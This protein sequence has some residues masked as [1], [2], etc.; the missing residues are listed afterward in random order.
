MPTHL[1]CPKDLFE[2]VD[3]VFDVNLDGFALVHVLIIG[4]VG[5]MQVPSA[6]SNTPH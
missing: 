2:V 5:Q 1:H 3:I 4:R 6:D